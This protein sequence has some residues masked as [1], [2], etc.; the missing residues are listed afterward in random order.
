[1]LTNKKTLLITGAFGRLGEEIC[2]RFY[3]EYQLTLIDCKKPP[4]FVDELMNDGGDIDIISVDLTDQN[5]VHR[6]SKH[7]LD[8]KCILQGAILA[9][10][11]ICLKSFHNI[12]YEEWKDT[13]EVNLNA[14]FLVCKELVPILMEQKH[15]HIVLIGS[16]LGKVACYDLFSYSVSKAALIHFTKNLAL[17]LLDYNINVNC[18]CPGFIESDM[19]QSVM[20]SKT[21]NRNKWFHLLGGLPKRTIGMNDITE[22]INFLI[23]QEAMT[24]E[25]I[26]MDGG[27]SIR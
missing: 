26:I 24:G 18:I 17:D 21:L 9:S 27:Y 4:T 15:G 12:T 1:M 5:S 11:M 23:N 13:F 8:K 6:I 19:F 25:E 2:R 16:V 20:E 7:I 10:G 22:L 14:N 3:R